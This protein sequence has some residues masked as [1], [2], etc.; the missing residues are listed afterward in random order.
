MGILGTFTTPE[1]TKQTNMLSTITNGKSTKFETATGRC[2]SKQIK[3]PENIA[4]TKVKLS[5]RL[6]IGKKPKFSKRN[7]NGK[8]IDKPKLT[9]T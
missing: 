4:N 2:C 6:L 5:K 8:N 7:P 3:R 1:N 9:K